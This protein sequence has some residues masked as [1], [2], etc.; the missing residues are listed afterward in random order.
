MILFL[1]YKYI[2]IGLLKFLGF[3]W[4]FCCFF[5]NSMMLIFNKEVF[6]WWYGGNFIFVIVIESLVVCIVKFRMIWSWFI[7][8][9]FEFIFYLDIVFEF[10]I[11]FDGVLLN[12]CGV[13]FWFFVGRFLNFFWVV[14]FCIVLLFDMMLLVFMFCLVWV[15][16]LGVDFLLIKMF[17][18]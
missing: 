10:E 5:G 17:R 3:V 8:C 2:V 7:L 13:L 15:I 11:F 1:G 12:V 18:L 9:I 6:F 4:K 16:M 14:F